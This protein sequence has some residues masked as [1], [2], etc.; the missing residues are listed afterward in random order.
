MS[1]I[2]N[3]CPALCACGVSYNIG[4]DLTQEPYFSGSGYTSAPKA[5]VSTIT[6]EAACVIGQTNQGIT[7]AFQG[8]V[9]D[10]LLSWLTDA[11]VAPMEADGFPGMVHTGFYLSVMS[12]INQIEAELKTLLNGST[13]TQ[14]LITGHSKGGALASIGAWYLSQVSKTVQASQVTVVTFASPMPGNGEFSLGFKNIFN[15]ANYFNYL[16]M[17]V[18]LPPSSYSADA[19]SAT[20]E[21]ASTIATKLGLKELAAI[22]LNISNLMLDAAGWDY[23]SAA[24]IDYF[25]KSDGTISDDILYYAEFYAAVTEHLVTGQIEKVLAAHS[26]LCGGGYMSAVCNGLCK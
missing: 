22:L 7:L 20:F 3:N 2:P 14:V 8:T 15:Q 17:V 23:T 5:I 25:I 21:T 4:S 10:S 9:A 13:N 16:D 26:H 12:I 24:A 1:T 18:F 19:W 6:N 11:I